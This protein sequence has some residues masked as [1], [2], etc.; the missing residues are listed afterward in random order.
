M[1]SEWLGVD[2]EAYVRRLRARPIDSGFCLTLVW[3]DLCLQSREPSWEDSSADRLWKGEN[4]GSRALGVTGLVRFERALFTRI[5]LSDV[6]PG[7][8]AERTIPEVVALMIDNVVR[9]LLELQTSARATTLRTSPEK[10]SVGKTSTA[11]LERHSK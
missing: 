3:N 11:T 2:T 10:V 4:E 5:V 9:L 8:C 1:Y 6:A 7:C